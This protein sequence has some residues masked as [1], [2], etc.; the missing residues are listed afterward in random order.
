MLLIQ[1]FRLFRR[2]DG[3]IGLVETCILAEDKRAAHQDAK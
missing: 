3:G 1:C 2:F